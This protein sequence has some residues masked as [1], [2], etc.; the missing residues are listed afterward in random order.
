MIIC[1]DLVYLQLLGGVKYSFKLL[2]YAYS[3]LLQSRLF[4]SSPIV[5]LI[6]RFTLASQPNLFQSPAFFNINFFPR[7]PEAIVAELV[8]FFGLG[9]RLVLLTF[10][11]SQSDGSDCLRFYL[12]VLGF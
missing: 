11:V 6:T 1:S 5:I 10:M 9:R 3:R 8:R 7:I 12:L 2:L 4:H